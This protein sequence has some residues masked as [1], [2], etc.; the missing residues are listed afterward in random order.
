MCLVSK[1]RSRVAAAQVTRAFLVKSVCPE[2]H[3]YSVVR[4]DTFFF[5]SF[6]YSLKINKN[7]ENPTTCEVQTVIRFL[8]AKNVRLA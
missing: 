2:E 1:K 3:V 5:L 4:C 6:L 8:N 7:I